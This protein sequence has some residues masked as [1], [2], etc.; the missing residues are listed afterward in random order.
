MSSQVVV[1]TAPSRKRTRAP[2]TKSSKKSRGPS[3]RRFARAALG[4]GFPEKLTTTLRYFDFKI[5]T[6][7]ATTVVGFPFKANGLYDPDSSTGGHQPLGYD[8]FTPIY[9]H[10]VVTASR[11][12]V[13]YMY[14]DEVDDTVHPIICG[15]YDDDDAS[16]SLSYSALVE[17]TDAS[18]VNY[19]TTNNDKV[20]LYSRW[21]NAKTF[22]PATLSDPSQRGSTSADP[23]ETHQWFAWF[24]NLGNT[25]RILNVTYE[26]EYQVT[27]F[28]RKDLAGS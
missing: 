15:I 14:R 11:I 25:D 27:F 8:Q 21:K 4:K 12:K 7:T 13:T 19:L 16:N 22:G 23:S 20:V 3:Y 17:G 28:E 5:P 10:W 6:A 24:Y 26:I 2:A 9:N 18:K 1:S